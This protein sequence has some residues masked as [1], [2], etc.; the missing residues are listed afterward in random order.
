VELGVAWNLKKWNHIAQCVPFSHQFGWELRL[1]WLMPQEPDLLIHAALIDQSMYPRNVVAT[2][3]GA[4]EA[5]ALLELWTALAAS[6]VHADAIDL[7]TAAYFRRTGRCPDE[8]AP[9]LPLNPT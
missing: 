5:E 2:G 4:D 1:E 6:G 7:V 9:S 8:D 3:H